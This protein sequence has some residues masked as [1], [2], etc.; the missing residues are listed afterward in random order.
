[1]FEWPCSQLTRR[2]KTPSGSASGPFWRLSLA[3][4]GQRCYL[5]SEKK[6]SQVDFR[7]RIFS[8]FHF[9]PRSSPSEKME[10]SCLDLLSLTDDVITAIERPRADHILRLVSSS[11]VFWIDERSPQKPLLGY[12]HGRQYDRSLGVLT[13]DLP[14]SSTPSRESKPVS[15]CVAQRRSLC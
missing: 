9:N 10:D 11:E 15:P 7:V 14:S 1:M 3:E 6:L 4:H 2:R 12:M 5:A 13:A 8:T